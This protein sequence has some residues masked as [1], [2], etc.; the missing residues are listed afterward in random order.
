LSFYSW[1]RAT[2]PLSQAF[3][4]NIP[5]SLYIYNSSRHCQVPLFLSYLG[6]L[7]IYHIQLLSFEA[8]RRKIISL[9][10]SAATMASTTEMASMPT[11]STMA[12][13]MMSANMMMVFNTDNFS[14]MLFSSGWMPTTIGTYVGTWFFLFFL[15]VISR[16][17]NLTV[18]KFDAYCNRKYGGLDIFSEGEKVNLHETINHWRAFVNIPRAALLMINQGIAYLL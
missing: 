7:S 15:A 8:V 9:S 11:T 18:H 14:T 5:T 17:V 1:R 3:V 4:K 10:R 2:E 12:D 13:S 16:W 6:F